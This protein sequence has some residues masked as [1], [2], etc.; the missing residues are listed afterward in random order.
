M[1][2]ACKCFDRKGK[3]ANLNIDYGSKDQ[4]VLKKEF[5]LSESGQAHY[6]SENKKLI[7]IQSLIRLKLARLKYSGKIRAVTRAYNRRP[8]K[9]P[10]E[11]IS[12]IPDYSNANTR[13][14]EEK[15]GEF[16]YPRV[17]RSRRLYNRG[18]YKL[19]N[20][21]IYVGEWNEQGIRD[22][23][24]VQLWPDGSKYTGLWRSDMA[25]GYGR[26]IHADGDVYEGNWV[27]DKAD[28]QGTYTHVDG[29]K[30]IGQWKEDKQHGQG[31]ETWPDGAK[32]S[33][34]YHQGKKHAF[35]KFHWADGSFFEG[36]FLHNNIHGS[37]IYTW[38]DQRKYTGEW[39]NNK[40]E[41]KGVFT[42][43]DGR[44]YEGGY[45]E[46]KKHG[47]GEFLWP[48]GRKYMG[49]WVAGKQNGI[50]TYVNSSNLHKKGEWKDGK[51]VRWIH[52]QD[53]DVPDQLI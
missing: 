25:N 7:K 28:G 41:G 42:W 29:A 14:T 24:G 49:N 15:M 26:L 44:R 23:Q 21:A 22:G 43:A 12:R 1:G 6:E 53:I 10:L 4:L 31:D 5:R 45:A 30:Y 38:N 20:S 17:E 32:Y 34:A 11:E 48:D 37:G 8:I 52:D 47:Y 36:N 40:M 13:Y 33:G 2:N 18:P 39:K 27:D 51:L 9:P 35:G 50:G 19:E 46:D 16:K 3:E